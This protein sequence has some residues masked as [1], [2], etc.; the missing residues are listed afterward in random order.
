MSNGIRL[1]QSLQTLTHEVMTA[2]SNGVDYDVWTWTPPGYEH[3]DQSYPLLIILDGGMFMGGAIDTVALM[4]SIGEARPAIL[5]GVSTAP[6][7]VHGIQRTIDYS[8]EACRVNTG[9]IPQRLA[10]Q[11]IHL[12]VTSP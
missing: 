5:V 1:P 9:S 10:W 2:D 4:S 3:S 11:V 7:G 12:V 6:P 8:A